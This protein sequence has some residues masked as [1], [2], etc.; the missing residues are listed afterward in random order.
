MKIAVITRLLRGRL[1]GIGHHTHELLLRMIASHPQIHWHLIY[2]NRSDPMLVSAPNTTHHFLSPPTRHPLLWYYWY[3]IALPPLLQSLQIDVIWYPDG[4]MSLRARVP[5]LLTIHDLAYKH[6][7][8]GTK[9]SHRKYLEWL[10]PIQVKTAGHIACV[11]RH[12]LDDIASSFTRRQGWSVV[13]NAADPRFRP[14]PQTEQHTFRKRYTQG[15]P[16]FLY[17]GAMHPRKNIARLIKAYDLYR[18]QHPRGY[19][20]VLAGRWAWK[21]RDIK[22]AL[23][24]S[25]YRSDIKHIDDIDNIVSPLVASAKA[26]VYVSLLEGFGMPV[27]EAMQSGVPVVTSQDSPMMEIAKKAAIYVDPTC[28]ASICDGLKRA[29]HQDMSQ[30]IKLGL[31]RSLDFDWDTS[32]SH[33]MQLLLQLHPNR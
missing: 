15:Q 2:D 25:H 6:F 26:L 11:S 7:P 20:L 10:M 1:E 5:C 21:T 8:A 19:S 12:T 23:Q 14:L 30:H 32:A 13:Y 28:V 4:M 27:L 17:L 22:D 31:K 3:E 33:M 18:T 9:W 16:Y 29:S 24:N